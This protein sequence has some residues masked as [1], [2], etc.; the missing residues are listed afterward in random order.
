MERP[1]PSPL[2]CNGKRNYFSSLNDALQS[3][4]LVEHWPLGSNIRYGET[5]QHI[6]DLN[7][8]PHVISVYRDERGLYER[9]IHYDTL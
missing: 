3:E 6:V 4:G 9:P 5:V 1:T 8:G 7:L 2:L